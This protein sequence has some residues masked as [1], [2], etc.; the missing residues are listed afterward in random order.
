MNDQ[1]TSM[2]TALSDAGCGQDA[3]ERAE[4]LLS[5]GRQSD[6]IRHLRL[7]RCALMDELHRAQRKVDCLDYL[8]R[9]TEKTIS[10]K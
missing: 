9:Q 4:R 1:L 2:T 8:I 3:I 10:A 5:A 7:C 6:L